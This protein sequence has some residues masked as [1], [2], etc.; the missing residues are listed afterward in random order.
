MFHSSSNLSLLLH[1]SL[2][3]VVVD[4]VIPGL[5][6]TSQHLGQGPALSK[7]EIFFE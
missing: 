5:Y 1:E 2:G 4:T 3:S 6:L 7:L